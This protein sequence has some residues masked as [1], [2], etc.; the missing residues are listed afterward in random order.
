MHN[1]NKSHTNKS[2]LLYEDE[3]LQRGYRS[4]QLLGVMVM[5]NSLQSLR[6]RIVAEDVN[7]TIVSDGRGM[8]MLGN[9][10]Y[11]MRDNNN[12]F[13]RQLSKQ[14]S[15]SRHKNLSSS[16]KLSHLL[17]SSKHKL[18]SAST[19]PLPISSHN[20]NSI[21]SK[22]LRDIDNKLDRIKYQINKEITY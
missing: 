12:N 7:N 10:D 3:E 18:P 4:M 16:T 22:L 11:G 2:L 8:R 20:T 1:Y 21:N 17:Y 5:G 19:N 15:S 9:V 6:Q 14:R 13:R